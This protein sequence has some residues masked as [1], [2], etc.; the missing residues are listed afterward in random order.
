MPDRMR[1]PLYK[2]AL[3]LGLLGWGQIMF[4]NP[5]TE[6]ALTFLLL[7]LIGVGFAGYQAVRGVADEARV[8]G[9]FIGLSAG[10]LSIFAEEIRAAIRGKPLSLRLVS[11]LLSPLGAG[12]VLLLSIG[13]AQTFFLGSSITFCIGTAIQ[14]YIRRNANS[15]PV[16]SERSSK[17]RVSQ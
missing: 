7:G 14:T 4:S 15:E 17:T 5:S 1:M 8:V 3:F 10:G 6:K 13:A 2:V 12:P 16:S 11:L 9:F